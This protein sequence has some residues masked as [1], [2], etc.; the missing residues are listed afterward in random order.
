MRAPGNVTGQN[1]S[2][3]VVARRAPASHVSFGGGIAAASAF[4]R[5]V[6]GGFHSKISE[7]RGAPLTVCRSTVYSIE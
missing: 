5:A 2:F 4:A 3:A 6:P 7:R 1:N